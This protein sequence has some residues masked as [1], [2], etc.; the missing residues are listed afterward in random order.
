[1]VPVKTPKDVASAVYKA[2]L[3]VL[4][5]PETVKRFEDLGFTVQTSRPEEMASFAKTEIDKYAKLIRQ[6]GM[7]LQ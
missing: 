4:S 3:A 5:K 6:T 1:M 2:T 7:A